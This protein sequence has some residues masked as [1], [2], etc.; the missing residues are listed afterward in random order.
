MGRIMN[1]HRRD[2]AIP[3]NWDRRGLPGWSY[4]NAALLEL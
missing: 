4:H 3:S 2:L 1:L